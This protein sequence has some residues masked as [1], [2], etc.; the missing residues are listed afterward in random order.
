MSIFYFGQLDKS[1]FACKSDTIVTRVEVKC[2]Y[3]RYAG[4]MLNIYVHSCNINSIVSRP[5]H[6]RTPVANVVDD[7]I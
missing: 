3:R 5:F 2:E 7:A 4:I 6:V 1:G